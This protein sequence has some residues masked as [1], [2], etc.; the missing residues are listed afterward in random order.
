MATPDSSTFHWHYT[1]FDDSNFQIRGST[2][3]LVLALFFVVFIGTI[4]YLYGR[5]V[6]RN[7]RQNLAGRLVH[8]PPQQNATQPRRG[9]DPNTISN[10]PIILHGLGSANQSQAECCICLGIFQD[11]EKIKV[12]PDCRHRYHSEC[13]DKWLRTHSSCPLCRASLRFESAVWHRC[14]N[15]F[16][17]FLFLGERILLH[18]KFYLSFVMF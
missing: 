17:L 14:C 6:C 7:S 18:N 5:W 8:A 10:L 3:F 13:V 4:F 15:T 11:G 9:L 12:L 1:E 16:L 2:L